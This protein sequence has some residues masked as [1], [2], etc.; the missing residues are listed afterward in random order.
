MNWAIIVA[1]IIGLS[2]L[3]G[4]AYEIIKRTDRRQ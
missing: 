1:A 2:I 3:A 4:F